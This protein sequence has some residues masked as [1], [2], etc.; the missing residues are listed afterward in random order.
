MPTALLSVSDKTGLVE[1]LAQPLHQMGWKLLA[2]GGTAKA[3]RE[4]GLPVEEIA[5]YTGSPEILSGRVKTLHPAVHG[6]LL[7]RETDQDQ[8][9]LA[10][11]HAEMIDMAVVNL[12]PFQKTVAKQDVTLEDAIENID[13]GGVALIRAAAKN[14]K[15]VILLCS[16]TDYEPVVSALQ[17]NGTTELE[18]RR[19]LA[20]KGFA[21]TAA[22]DRAISAYLSGQNAPSFDLFPVQ[23]LRYGE[24]PHQQATLYSATPGAGPLGGQLLQGKPLSYNNLLDL[25]AAWRAPAA[26]GDPT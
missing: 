18:F 19:Q 12:Y 4:A 14:F 13:I 26:G 9:D 1:K 10:R 24:N 22:Y 20:M 6:G 25:D 21:H 17:T 7:A 23:E 15:R 5:A 3:L 16:P 11:I 2:S 8:A